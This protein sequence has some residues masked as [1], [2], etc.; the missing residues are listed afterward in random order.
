MDWT[1][2]VQPRGASRTS[3]Q[4]FRRNPILVGQTPA[5]ASPLVAL[6]PLRRH[7]ARTRVCWRGPEIAQPTCW[8]ILGFVKP[9]S[10]AC[11]PAAPLILGR[12]LGKRPEN[13]PS[14]RKRSGCLE[15]WPR[16]AG[17][18]PKACPQ[19][20]CNHLQ[21]RSSQS[22][23]TTVATC[24]GGESRIPPGV[25]LERPADGGP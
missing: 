10:P 13:Y 6:P 16:P 12:C 4:L 17:Q 19:Q 24:V 11:A 9:A 3:V 2:R 20:S 15:T 1:S 7:S 18:V 22:H 25:Q 23:L 8:K 5:S 14:H 21:P